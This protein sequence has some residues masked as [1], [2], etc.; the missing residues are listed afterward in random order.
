MQAL[1]SMTVEAI[2]GII[3]RQYGDYLPGQAMWVG[4]FFNRAG[5]ELPPHLHQ[6]L[7]NGIP[8]A[9]VRIAYHLNGD[10]AF[11]RVL[12]RLTS[13]LEYG[14]RRVRHDDVLRQ[15]NGILRAE[16]LNIEME[17]TNPRIVPYQEVEQRQS[18]LEE[19]NN[20]QE[21]DIGDEVFIVHGRDIGAKDA[22]AR[23]LERI[24]LKP[25]VLQEM[26]DQG[27][28]VIEKFE[29]YA[30]QV[31]FAIALFTPDDMGSLADGT[32]NAQSRPRQNVIFELG[33][34]LGSLGRARVLRLDERGCRGTVRLLGRPP[35]SYG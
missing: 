21:S 13:P 19:V 16:G 7:Q 29:H 34:F 22:V 5:V 3:E 2:A 35:H 24:K 31:G 25:V 32:E 14:G 1:D 8:Y 6:P 26:P 15:I 27:A 12:L 17:G 4:E 33:Y 9:V 10:A 30:S 11:E 23:F 18:Q 28:T 20:P